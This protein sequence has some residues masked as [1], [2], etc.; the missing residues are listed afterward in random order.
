[1]YHVVSH[2]YFWER[3]FSD[4][5]PHDYCPGSIVAYAANSQANHLKA[6]KL[7]SAKVDKQKTTNSSKSFVYFYP[8]FIQG[9]TVSKLK[10]CDDKY[11]CSF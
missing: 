1:M 2:T 10:G 5:D 6:V 7:F 8:G 4:I 3:F 9:Q 11:A